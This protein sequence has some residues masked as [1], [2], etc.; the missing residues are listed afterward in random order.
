MPQCADDHH[1][2]IIDDDD[3]DNHD[4]PP[5]KEILL[6][7]Q[8]R[9]WSLRYELN[10]DDPFYYHYYHHHPYPRYDDA[11]NENDGGLFDTLLTLARDCLLWCGCGIVAFL[12]YHWWLYP[13]FITH[14]IQQETHVYP[15]HLD[16]SHPQYFT[17]ADTTTTVSLLPH[18]LVR[19]VPS[20]T[21]F[22][23]SISSSASFASQQQRHQQHRDYHTN[24][25]YYYIQIQLELPDTYHNRY[26]SSMFTIQY[27]LVHTKM[28]HDT[29]TGIMDEAEHRDKAPNAPVNVKQPPEETRVDE[30]ARDH[31]PSFSGGDHYHHPILVSD[32]PSSPMTTTRPNAATRSQLRLEQPQ[33]YIYHDVDSSSSN[34]SSSDFHCRPILD[35]RMTKGHVPDDEPTPR[36]PNFTTAPSSSTCVESNE[37]DGDDQTEGSSTTLPHTST[38]AAAAAAAAAI[39]T[40]TATTANSPLPPTPVVLDTIIRSYRYPYRSPLVTGMM[41][42]LSL[43]PHLVWHRPWLTTTN[44]NRHDKQIWE[45]QIITD[46]IVQKYNVSQQPTH[47]LVSVFPPKNMDN[48]WACDSH[49]IHRHRIILLFFVKEYNHVTSYTTPTIRNGVIIT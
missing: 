20:A 15:I 14:H 48:M 49:Q 25:K 27:Q 29:D 35:D 8:Q 2:I 28:D 17:N 47:P 6:Q 34:C 1:T 45:S 37:Y 39:D 10:R 12:T 44:T 41:N 31:H 16:Y 9:L 23:P 5:S 36:A 42:V 19:I 11:E 43:L 26:V 3:S 33:H 7:Q 32:H 13:S 30:S 24:S 40:T 38:A 22:L 46:T 21:I 4:N 18:E